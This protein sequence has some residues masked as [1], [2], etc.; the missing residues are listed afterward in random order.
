MFHHILGAQDTGLI[1]VG[2]NCI[3]NKIFSVIDICIN[4][5]DRDPLL[6]CLF[7]YIDKASGIDRIHDQDIDASIHQ[8]MNLIDLTLHRKLRIHRDHHISVCLHLI[9]QFFI[10]HFI[11]RIIHGH[12]GCTEQQRIFLGYQR[13]LRIKG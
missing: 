9:M 5:N 7:Q 2:N 10:D 12:I 6:F 13:S 1:I 3:I 4:G 11:K 8:H